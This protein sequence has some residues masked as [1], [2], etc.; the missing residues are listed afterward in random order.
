MIFFFLVRGVFLLFIQVSRFT[1]SVDDPVCNITGS[2]AMRFPNSSC[3]LCKRGILLT[4]SIARQL[5]LVPTR[6]ASTFSGIHDGLRRSQKH[7]PQASGESVVQARGSS[8]LSKSPSR[9]RQGDDFKP[10]FKIKK[11]KK[12]ITWTGPGPAS[13]RKRFNDPNHSFGKRSMVYQMKHGGLRDAMAKLTD[14]NRRSRSPSDAVS[15]DDFMKDFASSS[16]IKGK[17]GATTPARPSG[18][19]SSRDNATFGDRNSGGRHSARES[20]TYGDRTGGRPSGS[21]GREP[22][23]RSDTSSPRSFGR[24][25]NFDREPRG[26]SD[27]SGPKS[28][29][30]ELRE[31]SDD[32][33]SR[34]F[35]RKPSWNSDA[36]DSKSFGREP[37]GPRERGDASGPRSFDRRPEGGGGTSYPSDRN[38]EPRARVHPSIAEIQEKWS[39]EPEEFSDA[40]N[41]KRFDRRAEGRFSASMPSE[42]QQREF[43]DA[44]PYTTRHGSS[45][46]NK[47]EDTDVQYANRNGNIVEGEDESLSADDGPIRIH[48]TTA[49]SQFLYGRAV[50]KGALKDSRRKLYRLYIYA[51]NDRRNLDD[52]DQLARL[53]KQK[54]IR[55]VRVPNEGLRMLEKMSEGR[56]HNGYLLEAS[57]LP[58]LPVKALGPLA[59]VSGQTGFHV[60]IAHQSAEEADVNGTFNFIAYQL[61]KGRQPFVLLMD[62]ILDPGNLGAIIRSAAFLGVDG[63]AVTKGNSSSLTPVALKASAGASEVVTLFSIDSPLDFIERSKENGW[64][65]YASAPPGKVSRGNSH[66]T[67]DRVE[68][69]DPLGSQP[70][71]LVVGG[72]GEG[73]TKRVRRAADHEVSIPSAPGRLTSVV[74]S[75]NVSVATAILCA[76]FLRKQSSGMM[77][78]EETAPESEEDRI[79]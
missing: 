25:S 22:R 12:D 43:S 34:F 66:L 75:L 65:V 3:L 57:P 39:E 61:P 6:P 48:H 74:D 8:R 58:Q 79:W 37:R 28:F 21:F 2:N 27:A 23:E 32:S 9:G 30:R 73:L 46:A 60:D 68:S 70:T 47:F 44:T 55:V 42:T 20:A 67:I 40:P 24:E 78:I 53:A 64:L 71:I 7:G 51:G 50:V 76:A 10:D 13:R 11:G 26:R 1:L 62:G 41:P 59:E 56:P 31:W 52:D 4:P 45:T 33:I 54:G 16:G 69:Y 5:A 49:A 77:E 72:E 14:R 29:N 17:G 63:I 15:T 19:D 35:D 36:S 18:R 38:Q